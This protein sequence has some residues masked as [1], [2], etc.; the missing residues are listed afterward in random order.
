MSSVEAK[1][2]RS[3]QGADITAFLAWKTTDRFRWRFSQ[4]E[5]LAGGIAALFL[6]VTTVA[7]T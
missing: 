1:R 3:A 5:A 2:F 6:A 4:Q 7:V